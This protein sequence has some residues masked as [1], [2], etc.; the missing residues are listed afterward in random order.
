MRS[1]SASVV[2]LAIALLGQAI[3][4]SA[5]LRCAPGSFVVQT[6]PRLLPGIAGGY[7][8]IRL[9]VEG[10]RVTAAIGAT[11]PPVRA[12]TRGARVTATWRSGRCAVA[13]R[14]RLKMVIGDGC[15]VARGRVK[16]RRAPAVALVAPRCAPDGVVHGELGEQC[17]ADETCGEDA[18]CVDC[19][20]VP[21]VRF[22]RDVQ[23]IFT[24]CLTAACHEGGNAP[25]SFDLV[26]D[27][28]YGELLSK[29]AR[30]GACAGEPLVVPGNPDASVLFKRI[31]GAACGASMPLGS[32]L[33]PAAAVD[34]IRAWIAQ[35]ASAD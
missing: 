21:I 29:R 26:A 23:P 1:A 16:R 2:L 20:C 9:A 10:R 33:L 4:A 28:A 8:V 3:P 5:R 27:R 13:G 34:A 7:D 14:V 32:D 17:A 30:A 11:C 6:G 18:R 25:G 31:G 24:Q 19:R 22:A 15:E 35:G 12:R